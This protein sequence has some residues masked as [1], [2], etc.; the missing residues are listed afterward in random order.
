M[1]ERIWVFTEKLRPSRLTDGCFSVISSHSL[2]AFAGYFLPYA[3]G[4]TL[5]ITMLVA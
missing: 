5:C 3:N 1:H 4:W 2:S